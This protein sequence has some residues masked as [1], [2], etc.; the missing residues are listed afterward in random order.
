M[1]DGAQF[2]RTGAIQPGWTL[3]VPDAN[4]EAQ[5]STSTAAQVHVVEPGDS[6]WTISATA[7]GDGNRWPRIYEANRDEI[8][9]PDLIYPGQRLVLP[10]THTQADP[11]SHHRDR[12]DQETSDVEPP[13]PGP[14]AARPPQRHSSLRARPI[15]PTPRAIPRAR[16]RVMARR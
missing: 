10:R 1:P 7:Y 2:I 13:T 4:N 15:H 11:N 5:S 12:T 14:S 3:I 6:L 8:L 16:R 9:D